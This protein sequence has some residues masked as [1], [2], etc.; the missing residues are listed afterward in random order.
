MSLTTRSPIVHHNIWRPDTTSFC[1]I[2]LEDS[3]SF[4]SSMFFKL[5]TN[6]FTKSILEL[7]ITEYIYIYILGV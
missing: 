5:L 6:E 4:R 3:K 2:K 1:K 7:G